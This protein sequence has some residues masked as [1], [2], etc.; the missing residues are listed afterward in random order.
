MLNNTIIYKDIDLR[1]LFKDDIKSVRYNNIMALEQ[2]GQALSPV[3]IYR[4]VEEL[5][6][7]LYDKGIKLTREE[8]R[9]T[10]RE[11]P[12]ADSKIFD[13]RY[14]MLIPNEIRSKGDIVLYKNLKDKGIL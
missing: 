6:K 2:R 10:L 1:E 8:I 14:Y 13:N 7:Y 11:H 3:W 12:E 4:G 5:K 9:E